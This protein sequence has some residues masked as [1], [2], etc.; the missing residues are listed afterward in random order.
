MICCFFGIFVLNTDINIL[1]LNYTL[2]FFSFRPCS[3]IK[4]CHALNEPIPDDEYEPESEEV[5][6]LELDWT[7][8]GKETISP[9]EL[10]KD[11]N[12]VVYDVGSDFLFKQVFILFPLK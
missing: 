10:R 7:P 11:S 2:V 3:P 1:K 12:I 8:V 9:V 5:F 4:A 6:Q